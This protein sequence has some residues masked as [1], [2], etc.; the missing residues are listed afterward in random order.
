MVIYIL[1]ILA[2]GDVVGKCGCEFLREKLSQVKKHHSIDFVIANGENSAEGNGI[3]PYS[4]KH[5]FTSGVDVITTGNHAFR[6]KEMYSMFDEN[7]FILRPANYPTGTTPGHGMTTIDMGFV[8]IDIL[9]IQGTTYMQSLNCPFESADVFLKNTNSKVK[10]VD[11]HAEATAEKRA[12]CYYLDGKV[13]AIFGT[14]THIQTADEQIFP[15]GTGY[16]TDVGMTGPIDSILGVEPKLALDKIKT[17]LPV[18]FKNAG[19]KAKMD[20]VI[21]DIDSNTGKCIKV[22]RLQIV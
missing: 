15:G 19:G 11:F 17:K 6:R 3:T 18:R 20:C 8:T 4:A 5:L 16:I 2:I 21:F 13:S 7:N 14:H 9:N 1:R 12:L 10:F 22:Q